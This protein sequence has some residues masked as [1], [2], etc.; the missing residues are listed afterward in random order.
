MIDPTQEDNV[1]ALSAADFARIMMG[2]LG[3]P[4]GDWTR[5]DEQTAP[6]AGTALVSVTVSAGK[7]GYIYGFFINT[8][9]GNDFLIKW[10]SSGASKS[11]RLTFGAGGMVEDEVGTPFNNQEPA[12]AGTAITITNVNAGGKTA[13]YQAA[14]LIGEV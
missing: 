6:P 1:R 3:Y 5:A 14:L 9:E 10:T 2:I 11:L 8:Q 7:S 12:D 13:I 4:S